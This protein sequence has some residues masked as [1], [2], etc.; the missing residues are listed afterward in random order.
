MINQQT[1]LITGGSQGIGAAIASTLLDLGM[2]V[3]VTG[4]DATK[5][6]A[7]ENQL[8]ASGNKPLLCIEADVRTGTEMDRVVKSCNEKFG[9]IGIVI[10]NAGVGSF[11]SIDEMSYDLWHQTINTNLTG[12]FN[13]LKSSLEDL[14][15]SQGY[16][17][18]MASLAGTNF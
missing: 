14:K 1:A 4:R 5:L 9:K 17:I 10:A 2:N 7:L 13:T 15:S 8:N 16:F 12:V 3:A 6:S 11:V 18:T